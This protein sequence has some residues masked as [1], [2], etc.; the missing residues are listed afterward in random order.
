MSGAAVH[1]APPHAPEGGTRGPL[2]VLYVVGYPQ[3]M[4]GATRS[5]LE[6]V[7]NLPAHV[8]PHVLVM[9]EGE[10][11]RAY[12]A[13]GI[14]CTV[15]AAPGALGGFGRSLLRTSA[16]QRLRIAV[17]EFPPLAARVYRLI[18]EQRI[19]VVHANEA[20]AAVLVAASA[21]LA[22]RPLVVHLRGE[23]SLGRIGRWAVE[24]LPD[25]IVAVSEG[26]RQTLSPRGRRKAATVYN[27]T[28]VPDADGPPPAW[29]AALRREGRLIVC[30]FASVVPFKGQHHLVRAI[31]ALNARGWHDRVAFFA[32]GDFPDGYRRYQE[33]VG[34]LAR[35]LKVD[36]LT[37]AGW[38]GDPFPFYRLA[39]VTVL[40][41]VS[42]ELLHLPGETVEVRGHEGFPR[43]H[44]EAMAMGIPVVG[45]RIAGVPEQVVDGETGLLVPPGDP[46]ALAGALERLLSSAPLRLRLGEAARTRAL[47]RFSTAACVQGVLRE[48]A[49]LR[50]PGAKTGDD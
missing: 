2:R 9:G 4:A 21:R 28:R 13:A 42:R 22:R 43:T 27:G 11:A 23:M 39:D 8:Q 46:E 37:F 17:T 18:R 19:D 12:R 50:H 16:V 25:R 48:Y 29:P 5:L 20:R 10:V 40:P 34:E 44:L 1:P 14:P 35:E 30:C 33:W 49:R 41:S 31:A 32:I 15:L 6:L 47:E 38:Q 45:T 7:R 3:R 26:A 36:N 24:E